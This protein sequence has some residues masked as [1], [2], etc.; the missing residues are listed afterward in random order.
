[1]FF[2]FKTGLSFDNFMYICITIIS[3]AHMYSGYY[4]S[5]YIHTESNNI[6]YNN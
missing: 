4:Y 5:Q 1:M 2:F 3:L 6:F